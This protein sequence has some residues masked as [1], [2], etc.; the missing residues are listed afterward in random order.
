MNKLTQLKDYIYKLKYN[1]WKEHGYSSL[2]M[3]AIILFTAFINFNNSFVLSAFIYLTIYLTVNQLCWE[4]ETKIMDYFFLPFYIYFKYENMLLAKTIG[5]FK[6][7]HK[8]IYQ[9]TDK[10][11]LTN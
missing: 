8:K 10:M 4:K 11:G 7:L 1:L 2:I 5:L 6:A 9:Y 3:F